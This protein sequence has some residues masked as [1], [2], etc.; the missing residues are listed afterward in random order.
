PAGLAYASSEETSSR[1]MFTAAFQQGIFNLGALTQIGREAID[2]SYEAR[3]YTLLGDPALSLPWWLRLRIT[4]E[5]YTVQPGST[6]AL[7]TIFESEGDTRFGQTFAVTPTWTVSAGEVD[8]YGIYTAPTLPT[9]VQLTGHLGPLSATVLLAV[10]D[11][12][13]VTLTVTP[14]PLRIAVGK[15][16]QMT[17]TPYDAY[18][19]PMAVT[20]TLS[21]STDVG[22][23]GTVVLGHIDANGLFTAPMMPATGWITASLPISQGTST[24]LLSGAAWVEVFETAHIYLPLIM[25]Q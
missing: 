10:T 7:A 9:T 11:S 24:V 13:P 21:W 20:G 22:L 8:A 17:A 6:I 19:N 18:G 25:R 23:S 1:A 12:P 15:S 16:A 2:F 14:D 5:L 4:P 3:T